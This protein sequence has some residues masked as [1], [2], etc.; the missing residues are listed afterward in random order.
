MV[1]EVVGFVPLFKFYELTIIA[2]Q[3]ISQNQD[4]S[5]VVLSVYYTEQ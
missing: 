5:T 1:G 2:Y 4:L 3:A